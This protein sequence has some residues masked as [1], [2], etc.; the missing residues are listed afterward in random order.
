KRPGADVLLAGIVGARNRFLA[1]WQQRVHGDVERSLR[2]GDPDNGDYH[3]DGCNDPSER[4]PQTAAHD[5]CYVEQ[6]GK[7]GHSPAP[8]T[9]PGANVDTE[10]GACQ[11][12]MKWL[13][14]W[15]DAGSRAIE[16]MLARDPRT[17]RSCYGDRLTIADICLVTHLTSAKM[18]C[19]AMARGRS[20]DTPTFR[21]GKSALRSSLGVRGTA[22][23]DE[24][25]SEL[26]GHS[27]VMAH[28][29][30]MAYSM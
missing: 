15:L 24:P 1:E 28:P 7:D 4:H 10:I 11:P 22:K 12:R 29:A 25:S 3:D 19:D 8:H 13:R 20:T 17:G 23:S 14:H 5:P 9:C 27:L 21:V 30:K 16:D 18:L 2:P 26:K 6:K